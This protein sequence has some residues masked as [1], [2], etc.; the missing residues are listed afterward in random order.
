M[1]TYE[2]VSRISKALQQGMGIQSTGLL[3][4]LTNLQC[5]R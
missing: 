1:A 2:E 4:H 5:F 3:K